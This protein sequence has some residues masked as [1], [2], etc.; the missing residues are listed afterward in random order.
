MLR[1]IMLVIAFTATLFRAVWAQVSPP[2]LVQLDPVLN[3]DGARQPIENFIGAQASPLESATAAFDFIPGTRQAAIVAGTSAYDATADL[4]A[5]FAA[6]IKNG[7]KIYK[8]QPGTYLICG[9]LQVPDGAILIGNGATIKACDAGWPLAAPDNYGMFNVNSANGV[10]I[11]GFHLYGTKDADIDHTPKMIFAIASSNIEI[12][13]NVFE[14]SAFEGVWPGG[15]RFSSNHN[16]HDNYFKNI[17]Y[18]AGKFGS[19]QALN[20]GSP[21]SR[22]V[23]NHFEDVGDGLSTTA[24]GV[25]MLGNTF[26]GVHNNALSIAA[27]VNSG[28]GRRVLIANNSIKLSS[29]ANDVRMGIYIASSSINGLVD[30]TD[31]AIEIE[32]TAGHAPIYGIKV[33]TAT[34]P[35]IFGNMIDIDGNDASAIGID[36]QDVSVGAPMDAV[37][38][39]NEIYLRLGIGGGIF[40]TVG[41]EGRMA[42]ITA[43]NNSVK[44]LAGKTARA[45][46]FNGFGE[47]GNAG[48]MEA[49]LE[50][51]TKDGGTLSIFTAGGVITRT[52][53]Q[54]ND[55]PYSYPIGRDGI[56]YRASENLATSTTTLSPLKDLV[57][58]PLSAGATYSFRIVLFTTPDATGGVKVDMGGGTSSANSIVW[59]IATNAQSVSSKDAICQLTALT[60][61]CTSDTATVGPIII[62]GVIA[63]D[64]AGTLAPRVAQKISSGTSTFLAS[65]FMEVKLLP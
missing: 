18:P 44:G 37:L 13:A 43:R 49:I 28:T 61:S 55:L 57:S 65:S 9:S 34:R 29:H 16:V 35:R 1:R 30:V 38:D 36:I 26:D 48:I 46:Y 39:G 7:V 15:D 5:M 31:N 52:T 59:G 27:E 17:G 20:L 22:A 3:S 47:G 53:D 51:N 58:D 50:K 11:S 63:V 4:R 2:G 6:G 12:F 41:G 56:T 14:N 19:L 62:E 8:F 24:D 60:T 54:D 21:N 42:K 23:N 64:V 32:G 25:V 45:Y 10:R 40:A 33:A